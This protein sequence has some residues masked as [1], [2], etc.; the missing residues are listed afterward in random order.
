M[1]STLIVNLF[2][3]KSTGKK[4]FLMNQ[5]KIR[6][7]RDSAEDRLTRKTKLERFFLLIRQQNNFNYSS[8][9]Y[10]TFKLFWYPMD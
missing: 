6:S 4:W 10:F 3:L 1:L 2:I 8:F 5:N 7:S 9:A